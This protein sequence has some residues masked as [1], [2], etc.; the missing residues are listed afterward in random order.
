[1]RRH[2]APGP[3]GH[4]DQPYDDEQR[5]AELLGAASRRFDAQR[6]ADMERVSQNFAILEKYAKRDFRAAN[7]TVVSQ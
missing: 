3:H 7:F 1:M 2:A 6:E 4:A 5:T